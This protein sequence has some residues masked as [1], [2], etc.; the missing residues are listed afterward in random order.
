MYIII[1]VRKGVF[2]VRFGNLQDKQME[3]GSG[4][5]YFDSKPFLF[6]ILDMKFWGAESLS[7]IGRLLGIPLKTDRYTKERSVLRYARLLIN[8]PL[9]G[10]FPDYIEFFNDNEMLLRQHVAYEWKPLKC[11]HCHMFGHKEPICKKKGEEEVPVG[12]Q[13]QRRK[14]NITAEFTPVQK[15][16]TARQPEQATPSDPSL[17]NSFQ[18]LQMDLY[19]NKLRPLLSKLNRQHFADLRAQTE[20]ARSDLTNIQFI[21][22]QDPTNDELLQKE[23]DARKRYTDIMSSCLLLIQQ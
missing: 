21:L 12:S 18:A 5:C 23:L 15:R 13:E 9:D 4:V 7:K 14:E 1:H 22:Q 2:L 10:S 17:L 19:L 6:P 20:K 11:S 3:E 8:I 16:A